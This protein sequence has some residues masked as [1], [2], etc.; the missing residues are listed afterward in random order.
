MKISIKNTPALQLSYDYGIKKFFSLGVAVD[1]QKFNID[2][3]NFTYKN[4]DED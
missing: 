1:Y 3:E 2:A 4:I